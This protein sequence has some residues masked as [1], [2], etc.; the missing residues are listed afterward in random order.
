MIYNPENTG[1]SFSYP[2]LHKKTDDGVIECSGDFSSYLPDND[3]LYISTSYLGINEDSTMLTIFCESMALNRTADHSIPIACGDTKVLDFFNYQDSLSVRSGLTDA[4]YSIRPSD[5]VLSINSNRYSAVEIHIYRKVG[6]VLSEVSYTDEFNILLPDTTSEYLL[7]MV[8][9]SVNKEL[10][11]EVRCLQSASNNSICTALE[12]N[13]Q[14]TIIVD[15]NLRLLEVPAC[16][17]SDMPYGYWYKLNGDNRVR[18]STLGLY[19]GDLTLISKSATSYDTIEMT[20]GYLGQE[21]GYFDMEG[22]KEYFLYYEEG[23]ISLE[24]VFECYENVPTNSV[25][26]PVPFINGNVCYEGNYFLSTEESHQVDS[27]LCSGFPHYQ[28]NYWFEYI[29]SPHG[30]LDIE[31]S[32]NE[33]FDMELYARRST[34]GMYR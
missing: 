21:F 26:E 10:W 34:S 28:S 1:S 13:C 25:E 15:G 5:Q 2:V 4:W 29:T 14:D 3:T 32:H 22:G 6:D 30:E 31:V 20:Y 8:S 18:I 33:F 16:T 12:V 17:T 9:N 19:L 11:F 24:L 23:T 7:Q 27:S